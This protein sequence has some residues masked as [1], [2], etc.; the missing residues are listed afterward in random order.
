MSATA[1]RKRPVKVITR[2]ETAKVVVDETTTATATAREL[3][4]SF[5]SENTTKDERLFEQ[6]RIAFAGIA[7][8]AKA[9]DIAKATTEAVAE[10][11]VESDREWARN[12]SVTVGGAKVSRVTITQRADA[13]SSILSAGIETPTMPLVTTAFRAFTSKGAPGLAE[14]HKSLIKETFK[15][16]VGEREAHYMENA[17]AVSDSVV[18]AKREASKADNSEKAATRSADA[19]ADGATVTF[20]DGTTVEGVIAYIRSAVALKWSDDERATLMAALTEITGA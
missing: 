10:T 5:I 3:A 2:E 18:A 7:T 17:R 6:A 14:A 19:K 9:N 12:N 15:L 8:G 1:T 20:D 16:P 11:F 4:A 13:Y